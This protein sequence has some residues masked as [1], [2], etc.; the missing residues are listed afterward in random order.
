V[1][2]ETPCRTPGRLPAHIVDNTFLSPVNQR[3]I[4]L[5]ADIVVHSTTKYLNGR[6][7]VVGGAVASALSRSYPSM[8]S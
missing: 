3:P 2:W 5:G 6:S 4:E 7:D 8:L 1:T